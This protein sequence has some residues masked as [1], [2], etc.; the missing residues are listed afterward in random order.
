[1]IEIRTRLW[2]R[3]GLDADKEAGDKWKIKNPTRNGIFERPM[4]TE[5]KRGVFILGGLSL[6]SK[7]G[8]VRMGK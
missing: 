3:A 2:T 4:D 6:E 7:Y 5:W 8:K 1:M